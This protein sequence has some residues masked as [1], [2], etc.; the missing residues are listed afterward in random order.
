MRKCGRTDPIWM[1]VWA[2]NRCWIPSRAN[3]SLSYQY[4][5]YRFGSWEFR[6]PEFWT[7]LKLHFCRLMLHATALTRLRTKSRRRQPTMA[8]KHRTMCSPRLTPRPQLRV[9]PNFLASFLEHIGDLSRHIP[10][11]HFFFVW[12]WNG[13][14]GRGNGSV[15]VHLCEIVVIETW[16]R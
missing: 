16:R 5:R 4:V 2:V 13:M 15:L 3:L 1:K 7:L 10:L 6:S 8:K 9:W 14:M 11:D 12:C